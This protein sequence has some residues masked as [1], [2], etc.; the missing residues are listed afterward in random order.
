VASATRVPGA[1][2]FGGRSVVV[3]ATA[4]RRGAL[5]ALALLAIVAF[6]NTSCS[7][8]PRRRADVSTAV[9]PAPLDPGAIDDDDDDDDALPEPTGPTSR[10]GNQRIRRFDDAKKELARIY[11]EEGGRDA[12][13]IDLYCGCTFVPAAGRGLRVDLASCGY[14]PARDRTRAERIEWEHAVPAAL[15]GRTFTEW[16]E[17]HPRCT[18]R[19]GRPYHGRKCARIASAEFARMEA[20][21]HNL[22][23]VVG[24]VNGLRGDLPMGVLDAP[25]VQARHS[26]GGRSTFRFGACTSV[27]D[28]GVFVPRR[29]VRGDV[30]RAYKYMD[31]AYPTRRLLDDAHRAVMDA[32]DREDPPDAWER[33]R[34]RRILARQGNANE[35]IVD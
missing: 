9:R 22:F 34:N 29:E 3:K 4:L 19:S 24:E 14:T 35:F 21:L 25:D 17:G 20:D 13:R 7:S 1:A 2:V 31:R 30:A 32:W 26:G 16:R 23:P 15:F 12:H 28:H 11:S 10:G 33:E 5:Q 18:D 6:G 8:P 27:I